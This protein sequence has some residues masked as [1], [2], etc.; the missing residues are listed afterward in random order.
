M[1]PPGCACECAFKQDQRTQLGEVHA[2]WGRGRSRDASSWVCTCDV[3]SGRLRAASFWRCRQAGAGAEEGDASSFSCMWSVHSGRYRAASWWRCRQ[4]GAGA[5][6]GDA[7]CVCMWGEHSGRLR[8]SRWWRCRLAGAEAEAG[9]PPP[10]CACGMCIQADSGQPDGGSASRLGQ[11]QGCLVLGVYV[12]CAFRHTKGSELL[13]VQAG[14]GKGRG[15][16]ASSWVC[17]WGV[18][19]SRLRVASWWR[20]KQAGARA[21]ERRP[22]LGCACGEGISSRLRVA[23][24]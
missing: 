15:K 13:E 7:S 18:H 19:S 14:Y 11:R 22:R 8:A 3:H 1:P 12:G 20:C 6:E 9:M 2:G 24:C 17:M 4:A 21:E 16:E 5:E 23:S 10:G